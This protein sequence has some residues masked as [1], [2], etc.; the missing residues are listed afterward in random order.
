VNYVIDALN[1]A[2]SVRV[3]SSKGEGM[4]TPRQEQIVNLVV[5]GIGNR[6]IAQQL[7]VKENTVKKSLLRTYEKLGVSNRVEL[8]LYTLTHRSTEKC[9]PQLPKRPTVSGVSLT[10]LDADPGKVRGCSSSAAA[11]KN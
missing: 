2:P 6:E 1:A 8:V 10:C 11:L 5:E 3:L 7:H 9:A 4:L